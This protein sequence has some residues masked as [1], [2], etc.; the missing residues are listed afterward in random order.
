[1]EKILLISTGGTISQSKND[2]GIS[3]SNENS[4]KGD[5]F[6]KILENTKQKLG[7]KTIDSKTILNKDSSNIISE[8][9]KLIIDQIALDYDNY[10]AFII[11]HGTNTLGYTCAAL[12]FALTNIGK[13]VALTGSQISI[14]LPGSDGIFNLEN[15][16]RVLC[17]HEELVGVFAVFGSQI[18]TGTRVKKQTEFN[19][20]AFKTFGIDKGIG[21]IGNTIRINKEA[22]NKHLSFLGNKAKLKKDLIV[23]SD[24]DKNI[25]SLTE[26]PSLQSKY[27]KVLVDNGVKG[28]I[29]RGTGAGD[30]NVY[31][32]NN[33][34]DNLNL[35]LNYLKEKQIPIIV[36]TQAPDGIA[37]M[38]INEPGQIAKEMNAIPAYDMSIESMTVKLSWLIAQNK[39]YDEIRKLMIEP[40]KGEITIQKI[41]YH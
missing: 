33:N 12:S 9:W 4:M 34:L 27:I 26:F 22:L 7:I 29:M 1:M 31:K 6:A 28:F 2:D 16:L 15:T 40:L 18:I 25:M 39:S 35:A 5:D 30:L 14:G 21:V 37:S 19:Y 8:D 3:V 10:D 17:E 36:T 20:D 11:T 24:F 23:K 41:N 32:E 13:P 38:N